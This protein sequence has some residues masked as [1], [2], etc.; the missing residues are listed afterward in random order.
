MELP[1]LLGPH[2]ERLPEE[3]ANKEEHRK[4]DGGRESQALNLESTWTQLFLMFW[5][6]LPTHQPHQ[7]LTL[8]MP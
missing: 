1:G 8:I 2:R 4:C 5:S 3:E 7:H 6:H